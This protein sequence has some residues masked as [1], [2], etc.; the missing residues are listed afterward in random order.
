MGVAAGLPVG[1]FLSLALTRG[2][3]VLFLLSAAGT[4]VF[5]LLVAPRALAPL[6]AAEAA[7]G[8]RV[9]RRVAVVA[10]LLSLLGLACWVALQTVVLAGDLGAGA[11]GTVLG[12]TLFGTVALVEAGALVATLLAL[13][14]RGRRGFA[15]AFPP[16]LVCVVAE[17]AHGHGMAMGRLLGPFFLIEAVHLCAAAV[18]LGALP[19]LLLVVT[20]LPHPAG[21][22]AARWF[23]PVGRAAVI[24]LAVSA[25]LQ[26]W[27]LVGG[28]GALIGTAYGL[29]VLLKSVLFLVLLG[30]ACLNR[31]RFAPALRAADQ[32]VPRHRLL[33]SV[34]VQTA[35]GIA[36]VPAAAVLSVLT[37]GMDLGFGSAE[38][39]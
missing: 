30:L 38:T 8:W 16:S 28:F 1:V 29:V 9:L 39:G 34:L 37:P 32:A 11:I 7:R 23:S 26:G 19:P 14:S 15:F 4:I 31:Y 20:L 13:A 10:A 27:R 22:L 33:A 21:L 6:A 5:A 25:L 12:D 24:G 18:W 36:A 2:S 17:A 3:F 35:A